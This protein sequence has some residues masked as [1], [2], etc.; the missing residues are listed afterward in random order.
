METKKLNLE[1]LL[2][3]EEG[4][5]IFEKLTHNLGINNEDEV[6]LTLYVG[7][8]HENE[9]AEEVEEDETDDLVD[10]LVD[11]EPLFENKGRV[12]TIKEEDDGV[13][14]ASIYQPELPA[15]TIKVYQTTTFRK[16]AYDCV[17]KLMD[18]YGYV[19]G[20]IVNF[21]YNGAIY[22]GEII[23][24]H[25]MSNGIKAYEIEGFDEILLCDDDILFA[26]KY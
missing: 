1:D 26:E 4:K 19:V 21:K 2:K 23:R 8:F 24:R 3:T 18:S 10:G 13:I 5:T 12:I 16:A 17:E 25:C 20:D 6:E 9:E 11:D 14:L 22:E 15:K 7:G